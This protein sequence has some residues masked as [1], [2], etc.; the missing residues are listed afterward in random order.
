M[1]SV[2]HRVNLHMGLAGKPLFR[3]GGQELMEGSFVLYIVVASWS[4]TSRR[5]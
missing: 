1:H 3:Q 2:P 5:V 4:S